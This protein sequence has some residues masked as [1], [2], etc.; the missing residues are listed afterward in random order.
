[1]IW[2]LLFMGITGILCAQSRGSSDAGAH[3]RDPFYLPPSALMDSF[4]LKLDRG[5][6]LLIGLSNL[7]DMRTLRKT[8]SLLGAFREDMRHFEDSLSDPLSVRTIELLA[9]EPDRKFIR[10][11]SSRPPAGNYLLS[12]DRPSALKIVPDTVRLIYR[13]SPGSDDRRHVPADSLRYVV[14]T[15]AVND[16][17]QVF[18]Y[19][20][21]RLDSA[22]SDLYAAARKQTHW[23]PTNNHSMKLTGTYSMQDALQ[24]KSA[25]VYPRFRERDF[26]SPLMA[27]NLQN[28]Y[29]YLSPSASVGITL[30]FPKGDL[31]REIRLGWEPMFLFRDNGAGRL[32]T[33]RNDWISAEFD[34]YSLHRKILYPIT[35][36]F[37]LSYLVRNKGDFFEK[38]TFRLGLGG[39]RRDKLTV[40]PILYFHQFFK[41]VS[42]GL[43]FSVDF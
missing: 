23:T 10:I 14:L 12:G 11:R 30:G 8:D 36:N 18:D 9:D 7:D 42:P 38:N 2:V 3:Q 27:V 21:E 20:N 31:H 41:G 34:L 13:I 15:F 32:E 19:G 1:M 40:Q 37:S 5:N 29:Q 33:Y 22:L 6:S 35:G 28:V 16:F 24:G 25:R 43:R 17:H 26:L 4:Y 39:I